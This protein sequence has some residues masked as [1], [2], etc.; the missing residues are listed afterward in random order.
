MYPKTASRRAARFLWYLRRP[1]NEDSQS[2]LTLQAKPKDATAY[3]ILFVV[4]SF[5]YWLLA[6]NR[7]LFM[8]DFVTTAYFLTKD[9]VVRLYAEIG[10]FLRWPAYFHAFAFSAGRETGVAIERVTIFIAYLLPSFFLY[11]ALKRVKEIDAQSR[12][13]LA[14]LFAIF[15]TNHSRIA[16]SNINWAISYFGFYL[17]VWLLAIYVKKGGLILRGL[18]LAAFFFSFSTNSMLVFYAFPLVYLAYCSRVEVSSASIRTFIFRHLDFFAIP[19]VFFVVKGIF[20]K[21]FGLYAGYN[22]I[23]P[24]GLVRGFIYS[25]FS[26]WLEARV[27][28]A[29]FSALDVYTLMAVLPAVGL[30]VALIIR[31]RT[32]N[33]PGA[34]E[35]RMDS[36]FLALGV[37]A[38]Y[39]GVFPYAV[40]SKLHGL[41]DYGSRHALLVPFG[42]SFILCYGARKI[43]GKNRIASFVI[44]AVLVGAFTAAN[45]RA[46]ARFYVQSLKQRALIQKLSE[47]EI[48]KENTSF[49]FKDEAK[50]Y[51]GYRVEPYRQYE[52]SCLF[53]LGFGDERRIGF[54]ESIG[55]EE[56]QFYRDYGVYGSR[57]AERYCIAGY[58]RVAPQQE[59]TV[60]KQS[61]FA[62][63]DSEAFR[64]I[65]DDLLG[66]AAAEQKVR[67]MINLKISKLGNP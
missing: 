38:L 37:V 45:N 64:L 33:I 55:R 27:T 31:S 20:F 7:G 1:L 41:D 4:Y 44:V 56:E 50:D 53:K 46:F 3:A 28:L 59:V 21:P 15:P 24:V 23:G 36:L 61:N 12:L 6:V 32:S 39:I 13:I 22:S 54:T 62:S 5:S 30:L 47:N 25:F 17:A 40:V 60:V 14:V 57:N 29:G 63:T 52:W 16:L 2:S 19:P 43:A 26:Y 67:S 51:D 34:K 42:V 18:T 11:Y 8:D 66:N 49:L 58:Q 65:F 35:V 48:V 9:E 10:F